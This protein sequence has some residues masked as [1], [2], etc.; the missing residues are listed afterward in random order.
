MALIKLC[1]EPKILKCSLSWIFPVFSYVLEQ[2]SD[3]TLS[4]KDLIISVRQVRNKQCLQHSG[5]SLSSS[6]E[7][8]A[9]P[10]QWS[11]YGLISEH[12]R[13]NRM[14]E[15]IFIL[16]GKYKRFMFVHP[17]NRSCSNN[18][19]LKTKLKACGTN[20]EQNVS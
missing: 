7:N 4:E 1:L 9:L 8:H 3:V 5:M 15:S 17:V 20:V 19:P 13:V 11:F 10:F 18:E 12:Q 2:V 14:R 6:H 16:S